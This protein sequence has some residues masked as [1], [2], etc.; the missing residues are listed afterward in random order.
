M[1]L[2]YVDS[3][4]LV[5]VALGEPGHGE[6]SRTLDGY[7]VLFSSGLLEAEVLSALRRDGLDPASAVDY[8]GEIEWV[9]PPRPLSPEIETALE[10]GRLRGGDLWHVACA[11]F[12]RESA[13]AAL[14]FLS[15]DGMQRTVA[16]KLDFETSSLPATS[17]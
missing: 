10:A 2:G 6:I 16:S 7:E 12:A 15:L 4:C 17:G 13:G 3:S 14:D 8:I 11:L 5:A 1:S 9:L